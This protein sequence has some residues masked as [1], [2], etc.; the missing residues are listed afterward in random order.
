MKIEV[1]IRAKVDS[2]EKIKEKLSQLGASFI[3]SEAQVDKI[4]GADRFL[5]SEHKI[6]E[7]GLCSRIREVNG[8]AKLEIK[9][10]LRNK[11]GIELSCEVA[12]MELAEKMLAKL[13]FK[14]AFAIK[15]FRES[16]SYNGLEVDLDN[17]EQLGNFIEIEKMIATDDEK[18]KSKTKNECLELLNILSPG[19]QIETRKYG[20]MMQELINNKK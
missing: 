1:E 15:K 16:Y 12:S 17:V 18:E 14:E 13:D 9:E 6:I 20:D 3:K 10:I 2:F 8:K 19:S 5:D 7:G 11:G 4:F